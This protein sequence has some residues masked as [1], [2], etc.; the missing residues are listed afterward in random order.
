MDLG[1]F[2]IWKFGGLVFKKHIIGYLY[3]KMK[4]SWQSLISTGM[5]TCG[6]EQWFFIS[7]MMTL[8]MLVSNPISS[9]ESMTASEP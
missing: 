1:K 8:M 5:L 7:S 2:R 4:Q 9:S 6:T 3:M